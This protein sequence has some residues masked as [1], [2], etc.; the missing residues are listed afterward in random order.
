MLASLD[1][2]KQNANVLKAM[3]MGNSALRREMEENRVTIEAVDDLQTDMTDVLDDHSEIQRAISS[4]VANPSNS[5]DEEELEQELN[6]LLAAEEQIK[7][8]ESDLDKSIERRLN[9]LNVNGL[10]TLNASV[11]VREVESGH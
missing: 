5:I 9:A 1:D 8:K 7:A 10:P 6:E 3:K 2:T 11:G 4:P